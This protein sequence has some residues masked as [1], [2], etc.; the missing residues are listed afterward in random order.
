MIFT[1]TGKTTIGRWTNGQCFTAVPMKLVRSLNLSKGDK[2]HWTL[3]PELKVMIVRKKEKKSF[4][5]IDKIR[6]GKEKVSSNSDL[7]TPVL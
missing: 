6:E 4:D 2:L 5:F 7:H 1:I 3:D